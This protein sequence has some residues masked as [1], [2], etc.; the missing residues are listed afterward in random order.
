MCGI[1]QL[2]LNRTGISTLPPQIVCCD[3]LRSLHLYGNPISCL[4]D[5]LRGLTRLQFLW[6]DAK[7]FLVAVEE[8][9]TGIFKS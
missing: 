6:M 2:K 1:M 5:S 7:R 3:Q 9:M 4:P 8:G